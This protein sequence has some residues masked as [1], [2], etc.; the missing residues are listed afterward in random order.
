MKELIFLRKTGRNRLYLSFSI[1][2]GILGFCGITAVAHKNLY[3][4]PYVDDQARKKMLEETEAM[5][6]GLR[7]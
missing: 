5:L 2:N 6:A 7:I 4:I 1:I 3:G